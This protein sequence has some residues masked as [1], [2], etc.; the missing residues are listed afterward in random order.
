MAE[1]ILTTG[2]AGKSPFGLATCI[3]SRSRPAEAVAHCPSVAQLSAEAADDEAGTSGLG[4]GDFHEGLRVLL[5][6][7]ERES[8]YSPEANHAADGP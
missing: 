5:D 8:D 1:E 7:V 4:S 3:L 2:P 6:S